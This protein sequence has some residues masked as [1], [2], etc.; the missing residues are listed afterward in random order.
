MDKMS[1]ED[2]QL[3]YF[4]IRQIDWQSYLPEYCL[5]IRRYILNEKDDTIPAA[6]TSLMKF[7]VLQMMT[8]GLLILLV[9]LIVLQFF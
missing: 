8:H 9:A 5:G 1:A 2:R 6:R 3:F 7:Y 4:D